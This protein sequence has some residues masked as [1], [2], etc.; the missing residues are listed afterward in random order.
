MLCRPAFHQ[1]QSIPARPNG[2]Q[3][4]CAEKEEHILMGNS[5]RTGKTLREPR[6]KAKAANKATVPS[7]YSVNVFRIVNMMRQSGNIHVNLLKVN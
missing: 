6:L 1:H 4:N 2:T 3:H 5:W 7:L